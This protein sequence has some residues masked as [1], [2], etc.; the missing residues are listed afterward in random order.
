MKRRKKAR[1]GAVLT[2]VLVLVCLTVLFIEVLPRV[3]ERVAYPI[4]YR[5]M[6]EEFSGI[7]HVE[8]PL[9]AAIVYT[10]SGYDTAATSSVG[11]RG[12]MQVMPSTGEWIHKKLSKSYP[13]D[14]DVLYTADGALTYGCW[15]LGFL[16]DRFD[17]D[18]VT[19]IA[20]YHAG[21][22]EVEKWL[23]DGALSRDGK[24]LDFVPDTAPATRHYVEKVKKAYE[25]YKEAYQ[26]NEAG[27]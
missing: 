17:G 8:A 16:M 2:A 3:L 18:R 4:E 10:E 5:E 13:F 9:V 27:A 20:A 7:Y 21:Q 1:R 19:A 6:I 23:K 14:P 22:G 24:K 12:L 26:T 11:A 25:Y 15:Y